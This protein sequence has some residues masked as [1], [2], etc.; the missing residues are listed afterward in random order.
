MD[1]SCKRSSDYFDTIKYFPLL[2]CCFIL[3]G[4]SD[5]DN[6]EDK[7][8]GDT[9]TTTT[10]TTRGGG[11][12]PVDPPVAVSTCEDVA[13][14]EIAERPGLS[15]HQGNVCIDDSDLDESEFYITEII[16]AS[17]ISDSDKGMCCIKR[18]I[19]AGAE[20]ITSGVSSDHSCFIVGEEAYLQC[21][22]LDNTSGQLGNGCRSNRRDEH[23]FLNYVVGEDVTECYDDRIVP[24]DE[25]LK[26]VK[27]V[28]LGVDHSCA[29]LEDNRILCWGQ[30]DQG[31]LGRE[32][33]P[34]SVPV[35]LELP[36][37]KTEIEGEVKVKH[38]TAGDFHTC[39]LANTGDER[40]FCW[41]RNTEGQTGIPFQLT[42]EEDGTPVWEYHEDE[43]FISELTQIAIVATPNDY[44]LIDNTAVNCGDKQA[45]CRDILGESI[46]F[47]EDSNN[48]ITYQK[49]GD[50]D[51]VYTYQ[52]EF[53]KC[54]G[55]GV[56]VCNGGSPACPQTQT[57]LENKEMVKELNA[58]IDAE[59]IRDGS[60]CSQMGPEEIEGEGE[61]EENDKNYSKLGFFDCKLGAH[62]TDDENEEDKID[63]IIEPGAEKFW[64][65]KTEERDYTLPR[66]PP[67]FDC[68]EFYNV[69]HATTP[70][71]GSGDEDA[72][73]FR[74]SYKSIT[75]GLSSSASVNIECEIKILE[76]QA[77]C[78]SIKSKWATLLERV[79]VQRNFNQK[80]EE[81]ISTYRHVSAGSKHTCAINF[82]DQVFCFGAQGQLGQAIY[83]TTT[84][85]CISKKV[86]FLKFPLRVR[87]SNEDN[88]ENFMSGVRQIAVGGDFT[89]AKIT[90]QGNSTGSKIRCWGNEEINGNNLTNI[91]ECYPPV[92][93]PV[94]IMTCNGTDTPVDIEDS[95]D[96]SIDVQDTE[97]NCLNGTCDL[98]D[99]EFITAGRNH[100]CTTRYCSTQDTN[101]VVCWGDSSKAQ[102]GR[103][104]T[105]GDVQN[106]ALPV[107]LEFGTDKHTP[108]ASID[109]GSLNAQKNVTC[110][111]KDGEILC[112]GEYQS[113][114][115]DERT[116]VILPEK[117][118][119]QCEAREEDTSNFLK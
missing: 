3:M 78:K 109:D 81:V 28:V 88:T 69:D 17:K 42:I 91:K 55:G 27:Q 45:S 63:F 114:L 76:L 110:V 106:S 11:G 16:E 118:S 116:Q 67:N 119:R 4:C 101:E 29:L 68:E 65:N 32:R 99:V 6:D 40:I 102:L 37:K 56:P 41:G 60:S 10:S 57:P 51:P 23:I 71:N 92:R 31:Q 96:N 113:P 100:V 15:A 33:G 24:E 80:D 95:P 53:P 61:G 22:G 58:R 83:N 77:E 9:T 14:R 90:Q 117:L 1:T 89:C 47:C 98:T 20:M 54:D 108:L 50:N 26:G 30:N 39:L 19:E 2:I 8:I 112:W 36:Q 103:G 105:S 115:N 35:A 13:E 66:I 84:N 52:K 107:L 5:S 62:D 38:I 48:Y 74:N 49:D 94:P 82:E 64:E 86:A 70:E 72:L 75:C 104:G 97:R 21:Y 79:Y 85:A 12:T 111:S 43:D 7:I 44:T 46:P 18:C 34:S 87:N 93:V 59:K 25:R 73:S